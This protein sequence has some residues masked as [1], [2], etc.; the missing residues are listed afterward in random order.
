MKLINNLDIK[1]ISFNETGTYPLQS[2]I[3]NMNTNEEKH[4]LL[5]RYTPFFKDLSLNKNGNHIIEKSLNNL[6][7]E[8]MFIFY[9]IIIDNYVS[10]ANNQYGIKIIKLYAKQVGYNQSS[11]EMKKNFEL[12]EI[13]LFKNIEDLINHEF[14][15]YLIQ[16]V[17]IEWKILYS[18]KIVDFYENRLLEL[19]MNKY[20]SN[21]LEK[22][23][24]KLEDVRYILLHNIILNI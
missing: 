6:T 16:T 4:I 19:S 3:E 8:Y 15:N 21:V 5:E 12:F 7:Y 13:E 17:I 18:W 11:L 23:I 10:F 9:D 22:L 14:G 2:I 24:F 1:Y 20:S